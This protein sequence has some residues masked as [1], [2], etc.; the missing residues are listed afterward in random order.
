SALRRLVYLSKPLAVCQALSFEIYITYISKTVA[1][2][3]GFYIIALYT[4]KVKS[5]RVSIYK[6]ALNTHVLLYFFTLLLRGH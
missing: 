3:I 1:I 4:P 6:G 2:A 5:V